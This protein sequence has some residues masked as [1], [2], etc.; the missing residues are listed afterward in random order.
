[1]R[2]STNRA[3]VWLKWG[4]S[5]RWLTHKIRGLNEYPTEAELESIKADL[6]LVDDK[7]VDFSEFL[8]V[9]AKH[10]NKEVNHEQELLNAFKV[11]DQNKEGT[12]GS[13]EL[14][15]NLTHMGEKFTEEQLK[16][17]SELF[18]RNSPEPGKTDYHYVTKVITRSANLEA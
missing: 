18:E 5:E 6:N 11:F 7:Y 4:T 1:M 8:L 17:L 16:I 15:H 9:V 2:F 13:E 14:V 10:F 3:L 12:I